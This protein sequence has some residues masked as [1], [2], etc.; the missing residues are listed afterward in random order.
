MHWIIYLTRAQVS[1]RR[2]YNRASTTG[3]SCSS[4]VSS[5][6]IFLSDLVIDQWVGISGPCPPGPDGSHPECGV[7]MWEQAGMPERNAEGCPV[8]GRTL[9]D[10]RTGTACLL[11]EWA[12]RD[13]KI[14]D[15]A[16]G[17]RDSVHRRK[18]RGELLL[19]ARFRRPEQPSGN[20][21]DT[22][23]PTCSPV[24]TLPEGAAPGL[25]GTPRCW[26]GVSLLAARDA[27]R[28]STRCRQHFNTHHH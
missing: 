11:A 15:R 1:C 24:S 14:N 23:F 19:L 26:T 21:S 22:R 6:R 10:W 3:A 5:D 17:G 2:R 8:G 13:R 28:R 9:V 4:S 27:C 20:L 18:T 7:S 12:R 25:E 16:D